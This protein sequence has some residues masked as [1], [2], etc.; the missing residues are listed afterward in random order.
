M[1]ASGLT[2]YS[3]PD[4]Y[5]DHS[6]QE[7]KYTTCYM[8]ACRC[9]VKVYVEDNK[10]RYLKG[11]P[12]HPTNQGVLCGKGSS[13]IMKQYSPAKLQKPLLRKPGA[14]RGSGEFQEISW[15][16]A[17]GMLSE[18]LEKIRSS[19][20]RKL[21]FFTGRD[22][23]QALT[24]L[25]ATQFGTP[26]FAAHGGFCSVNMAAGGIYTTGA[27]FWE[28]GSPDWDRTKY[29]LMWG[30]AE[31]HD[32][33]PIKIGLEKIKRRGAKFVAINPV[34][35][36]YAAIADEWVGIRPGTDA[37]LALSMV[38]VLLEREL[39]DWEYLVRYTNAPYLVIDNEGA[40]DHGLFLRD[41]NG[42]PQVWDQNS[43]G[44]ADATG[45]DIAPALFGEYTGPKG[46]R[47]KTAMTLMAERYLSD[48]YSPERAAEI[49]GID[50]ERIEQIALEMAHVA[51]RETI[52]IDCEWTDWAG[53]KQDKFIGRPVSMHAMRGI[54]AHSN[55]FQTC[56]SI[57][58]LQMLLGTVDVPG[59][60][61]SK[62]PFPK[63]VPPAMKPMGGDVEK[64]L[65][66]DTPLAGPPLGQPTAP[67][68]LLF[69]GDGKPLRIDKA[70]TWEAP[71]A[72]H[73]MMH[74]VLTNAY[75]ED[76]YPI[77]T[78]MTFMANMSWNS[79]MNTQGVMEMLTAKKDDGE[80]RIPFVVVS[81][82]FHSEMV[83]YSD[84][85]LPDTTYFERYDCISM[86]DRPI[87]EP[88]GPADAIRHPVIEPD[89][90]VRAFQDVLVDLASRLKLPA[91]TN[92]DGEPKFKDYKDFIVNFEKA[93]GIGFLSG[94][95]G[96]SGEKSLVGEPNPN[97]WEKYLENQS[98][99]AYH[100]PEHMRFYKGWNKDYLEFAKESGYLGSS[101]PVVMNFYS[102]PLQRFRLAGE[103]VY[104]GPKP[105]DPVDRERLKSYFDPL[106]FWYKPLEQQR[107]EDD[108]YPFF[109][110]TQRPMI[111]YHSW[112]SQNAWQRQILAKNYLY[113]NR[114]RAEQLGIPDKGWAWVESHH[115]KIRCQVKHMEGTE[116]TTV[117]TYN[118]IGKQK[119]SWGLKPNAA[120]SNEGFLMNHL[121]S[122]LL[123]EKMGE[124]RITNS[125]PITG[126]AAWFDLRV[127][128][129]PAASG[130][131]G[132]WPEFPG[133]KP[134]P[135]EPERPEVLR[136]DTRG[137]K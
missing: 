121:I 29:F 6:K 33:N 24:G 134:F 91:F 77:D 42:N 94:W 34:R 90:D 99:F 85:V 45:T 71:L 79:T 70:Y 63:Q 49:T 52:E 95:R 123:P 37:M 18:R 80:Y 17:L 47:V 28:F 14:E 8:C 65:A 40:S 51:F 93:P 73:G 36:G 20:P 12:D 1:T 130:E 72:A 59:G 124:R 103:G 126:Q 75:N 22:Q 101:E 125:D 57:H 16:E 111:M 10:L 54:S 11:N 98:F 74:M 26:N 102:E 84:L 107:V 122:E 19:D 136:Y 31:D 112:D 78:F 68:D 88:D 116:P 113:M 66:P 86:L 114:E 128:I 62:P 118:A 60:F 109:A 9:G 56:R 4:H 92:E 67:E 69:D 127:K 61:R 115:G 50:A 44:F 117:W 3:D 87:S 100:L 2:Y 137:R 110:L 105:E 96:K 38:H 41:D 48:E 30:V 81:D 104:E 89:R 119:G 76:P 133:I 43:G 5:E 83:N 55:G 21:A 108:E 25:W 7:V 53:R 82:A 120:E 13:G 129:S 46:E 39:F 32:S 35:T 135:G 58:F 15:E 64:A 106:P 131:E 97:Q 27:P 23:M 132:V